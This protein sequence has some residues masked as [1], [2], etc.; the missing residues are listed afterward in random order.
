MRDECRADSAT[1]LSQH[2]LAAPYLTAVILFLV[3]PVAILAVYSF[4]TAGFLRVEHTFTFEN[5]ASLLTSESFRSVLLRS[6][7]TGLIS[8]I[9]CTVFAFILCHGIAFRFARFK[10]GLF[11]IIVATSLASFMGRVLSARTLLGDGGLVNWLLVASGITPTPLDLFRFGQAATIMTLTF[12]WMPTAC[13]ILYGSMQDIDRTSLEASHD[14]GAGRL[15]TLFQVTIPQAAGGIQAAF[16]LMFLVT[17][18]DFITPS[19]VGGTSG[20]LVASS[21]SNA[22]VG[23]GNLPRGAAMAFIT[24]VATV[25][26]IAVTIVVVRACVGARAPPSQRSTHASPQADSRRSVAAGCHESQSRDGSAIP[27]LPS[28]S[29]PSPP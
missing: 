13:L 22:F 12:V 21:I 9:L 10:N 25:A 1:R 11:A 27:C 4:W 29:C 26:S 5:Y 17:T 28:N 14:L 15:R 18:A 6:L 24:I 7:G 19:L 20:S 2:V 23:E 8:A 3:V 16:A